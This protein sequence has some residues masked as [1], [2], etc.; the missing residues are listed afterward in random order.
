[1]Y[2][3]VRIRSSGCYIKRSVCIRKLK[4]GYN[5]QRGRKDTEEEK[6]IDTERERQI[7]A[8]D[9]ETVC[10]AFRTGRVQ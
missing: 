4:S 3:G 8:T 7:R 10:V 5:M 9:Y 1:M 2:S 6:Y